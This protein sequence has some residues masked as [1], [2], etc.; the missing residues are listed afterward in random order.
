MMLQI[1]RNG[2]NF[3]ALEMFVLLFFIPDI[4]AGLRRTFQLLQNPMGCL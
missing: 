2:F 4:W 1:C 3:A